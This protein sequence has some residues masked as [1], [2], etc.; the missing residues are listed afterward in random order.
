VIAGRSDRFDSRLPRP[1]AALPK[2]PVEPPFTEPDDGFPAGSEVM[3]EVIGGVMGNV[4]AGV[5]P[6]VASP[7]S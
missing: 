2:R 3:G 6:F 5:F 4:T 1:V 7:I